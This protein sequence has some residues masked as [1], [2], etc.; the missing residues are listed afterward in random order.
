[1]HRLGKAVRRHLASL[2]R[3][4]RLLNAEPLK[5]VGDQEPVPHCGGVQRLASGKG[6]RRCSISDNSCPENVAQ[7]QPRWT[8]EVEARL[9]SRLQGGASRHTMSA[10]RRPACFIRRR[11]H[12]VTRRD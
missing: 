1:M 11:K 3:A 8:R 5:C 12:K 6:S 4:S 7:P 10:P 2:P 9:R